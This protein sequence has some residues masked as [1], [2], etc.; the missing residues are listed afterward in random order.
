MKILYYNWVDYLDSENRGGGVSIYQR[1]VMA[2]LSQRPDIEV[3]FLTAGLSHDLPAKQPR[4]E[5]LGHGKIPDRPHHYEIVNSGVL[6]PAHHC[7]GDQAQ[8]NH[9]ATQA[10]FFDFIEQ[11]GPYDVIHFNNIEGLPVSALALKETWPHTKIILSLHNYYPFCP[12]VNFWYQEKETCDDFAEGRKCADCLTGGHDPHHIK[13]ANGLAYRLKKRG[14]EPGSRG[15]QY[16][17]VW[18]MRLGRRVVGLQKRLKHLLNPKTTATPVAAKD[19]TQTA[20]AFAL[21]RTTMVET[22]NQNCD[23]VLC[24]SEAVRDI[25]VQFGLRPEACTTSYIGTQQAEAFSRTPP[26]T[27]LLRD[28]GT[29]TL[30]FLGYMRRDKGFMFLLDALEALPDELAKR[31][32]FTAAARQGDEETMV[33]FG[34]LS[35]RLAELTHVDGYSHDDLEALLAG[36]DVGVVPVLWHDNLPQ[37]AIELHSRH[38]PLL[39]ADMGG[40]Q[41]LANCPDMVFPAGDVQAFCARI[42]AILNGEIDMDAYWQSAR[43]PTTMDTHIHELLSN[44]TAAQNS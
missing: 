34:K 33:R 36:I 17:F 15:F 4:W 1:N 2:E 26:R 16:S 23:L 28:D 18:I 44:Y 5:R 19:S 8:V 11:T 39:T 10:A 13:L 3:S 14:L 43:A 38:I 37:V 24:V 22:I 9:S 31:V 7:F 25:A 35:D 40:A 42:S 12:Q 30:G 6:A 27:Q 29:F 41:E 21:R 20:E 32:R